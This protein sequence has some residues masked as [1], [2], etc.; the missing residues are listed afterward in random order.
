MGPGLAKAI[1]NLPPFEGEAGL[2][3]VA[4]LTEW[5][6][7]RHF[8][9]GLLPRPGGVDTHGRGIAVQLGY[10]QVQLHGAFMA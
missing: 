1:K 10:P 4:T 8:Q 2:S 6:S 7:I 9:L 3:V 5:N